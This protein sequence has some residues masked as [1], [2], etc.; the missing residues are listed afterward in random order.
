MPHDCQHCKTAPD[1][2]APFSA[3]QIRRD[4]P[5]LQETV[6][7]KPLIYLDNAATSQKPAEVIQAVCEYYG[8]CNANVHRAFHYL[9]EQATRKYENARAAVARFVGA[10][11]PREI[12]FTRG[13]TEAINLVAHSWGRTFLRKGDTLLLTEMEHH[14]N[15]IP[16]QLTAQATGARLAF[17]P[18]QS[19]GTLDLGT[20]HKILREEGVKLVA[21]THTSN[22]LGTVNPLP[23]MIRAAH[24]SGARVL[25][26][27]AQGV[28]HGGVDVRKL[29]CDFL[30]FSGH[31]MCG[32]TGA[33][34]LYARAELLERMPPFMSGGEMIDHVEREHST[35]AEIPH[36]FEAGTPAVADAIGLGA[37]VHYL[38]R[39]G[40]Q[41]A[42][43]HEARLTALALERLGSMRGVKTYGAAPHRIGVVSFTVEGV[44]PHDLAQWLDHDGVAIRAGHL[45][46]QPLM[47]KL[48]LP[49]VNRA[50]FYF[51]N[52][53]EEVETL[54]RGIERAQG[55]FGHGTG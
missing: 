44:H 1:G 11:F 51:Y 33:G 43:R 49:A 27:G 12:I 53:P 14:S 22:A 40:L 29:D 18:V 28:P 13:T 46:C 35:W 36:K 25:V 50:S 7:G 37:A 19:D 24:D 17:V 4:F 39:I 23:D 21:V 30:A 41:D 45:C 42:L 15:L 2:H 5:V 34:A 31:K 16:W 20:F 26:D 9:G 48:G 6:H 52:L 8:T 3:E 32:P 47:R 55:Y 38:D 10:A 54:A